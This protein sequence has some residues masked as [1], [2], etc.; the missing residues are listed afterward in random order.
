MTASDLKNVV[1]IE[2]RSN[3]EPWSP[4]VFMV[5]LGLPHSRLMVARPAIPP[6]E[7]VMGFIC[8]WLVADE[9]Q[10]LNLAVHPDYRH[11]GVARALLSH[12]LDRG[13]EN[14][15]R[16]AVLEVR[17]SNE[18]AQRLYGGFGFRKVGERAGYYLNR[19]NVDPLEKDTVSA[20]SA[21]MALEAGQDSRISTEVAILMELE[22]SLK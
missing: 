7:T 11:R 20:R 15:A 3:L 17:G 21:T 13:R 22:I 18:A 19:S 1:E 10:I 9:L 6:A 5:E 14:G 2:N 4:S 16:V 8:F 12:C